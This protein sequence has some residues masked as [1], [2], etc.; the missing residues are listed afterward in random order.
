MI[1]GATLIVTEI[2]IEDNIS[3]SYSIITKLSRKIFVI[4]KRHARRIRK[5]NSTDKYY[6][7]KHIFCLFSE[8]N[9]KGGNLVRIFTDL[10][11]A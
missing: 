1:K 3:S 5:M 2:K 4:G 9:T 11:K 10:S 8:A 7:V 6:M